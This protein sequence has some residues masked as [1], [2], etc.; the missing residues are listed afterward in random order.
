MISKKTWNCAF[1]MFKEFERWAIITCL[2]KEK[3]K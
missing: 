1:S 2:E 3:I